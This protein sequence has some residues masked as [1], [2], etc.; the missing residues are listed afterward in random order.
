MRLC[1]SCSAILY[2]V[3]RRTGAYPRLCTPCRRARAKQSRD[4]YNRENA[5]ANRERWKRYREQ[6]ADKRSAYYQRYY[7]ERR[8]YHAQRG[9]EWRERNRDRHRKY[10]ESYR[11]EKREELLEYKRRYNAANQDRRTDWEAARRARLKSAAV[12]DVRRR[13]VYERDGGKCCLR[14]VCS[15]RKRLPFDGGWHLDHIVPLSHGGD[16]SYANVQVACP[17]C[18]M[19]KGAQPVGEQTRLIG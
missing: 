12:E 3:K 14:L 8:E 9:R 18:N 4:R 16:H 17:E 19:A 1:E 10:M 15:G 6:N 5:E 11:R 2:W 7:A 13:E